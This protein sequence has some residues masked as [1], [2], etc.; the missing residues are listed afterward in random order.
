[1]LHRDLENMR[2]FMTVDPIIKADR[3]CKTIS[4]GNEHLEILTQVSLDIKLGE[5]VA[6]TGPSGAGKT[7]LL[8]LLAGLD[9]PTSGSLSLG[10]V[11]IFALDEE[12]RTR[13]RGKHI[14]F[15]F[16]N[17]YL[18]D[19][20]TALENV[21]LPLEL[22]NTAGARNLAIELLT[23]VGLNTRLQHFP[24][25]LSGGEQQR[26]A[27]ARAFA[28]QPTI[29][30]ADEPTGNLDQ[31]TAEGVIEKIFALNK[32][33]NTTLVMITHEATLAARC[34]RVIN[35]QKGGIYQ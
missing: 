6:I 1:M 16:Q 25:Q 35:M 34:D 17:F 10:G 20:L 3:L 24:R 21:M 29:L 27:V 30:F 13:V 22:H 32:N 5:S 14:S 8:G 23:E 18:L 26:V 9:T 33:F 4:F 7:T 31:V 11:D 12:Q 28:L 2:E 15:I 19:N